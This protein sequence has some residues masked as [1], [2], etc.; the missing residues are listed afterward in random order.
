MRAEFWAV[1]TAVCWGVGSLLEKKGVRL[2]NFSPVM[3][4]TIRTAFSLVLLAVVSYPY[5]GQ[6]KQASLGSISLIAVG[7]GVIAGA[8]GILFLYT[9]LKSGSL[10]TVMAIAF[11]LAPVVGALLG[12]FVLQERLSPVQLVGVLLCVA[13]AA[14]VTLFKE[15]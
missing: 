10:S 12:F 3:G 9:G 1:L 7:G 15:A 5:W 14:L 8:L 13:G 2:G 11:C 4:T 6:V